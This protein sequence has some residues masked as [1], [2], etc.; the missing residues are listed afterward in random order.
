MEKYTREQI[1]KMRDKMKYLI[2]YDTSKTPKDNQLITGDKV[3]SLLPPVL[4]GIFD[5]IA[6]AIEGKSDKGKLV[7]QMFAK[8]KHQNSINQFLCLDMK[9]VVEKSGE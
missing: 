8:H 3:V 1:K 5:N 2:E 6:K 7:S 9:V 4:E